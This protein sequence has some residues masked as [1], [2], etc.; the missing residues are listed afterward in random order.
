MSNPPFDDWGSPKACA[1]FFGHVT[2]DNYLAHSI[3]EIEKTILKINQ[4]HYHIFL[5]QTERDIPFKIFFHQKGCEIRIQTSALS[6]I[7]SVRLRLAH[8]LGH[9]VYNIK[10]LGEKAEAKTADSHDRE[11]KE[12]LFAWIFAYEL[13]K[14]KSDQYHDKVYEQFKYSES[15]LKSAVLAL[16]E[17]TPETNTALT[18]YFSAR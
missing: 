5:F 17:D 18:T 10:S 4:F 12:E 9:L 11:P 3:R 14:E 7:K 16:T 1:E 15:E 2:E 8:E 6:S 13:I